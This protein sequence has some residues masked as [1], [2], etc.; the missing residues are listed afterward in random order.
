VSLVRLYKLQQVDIA[1]AR[2]IAHRQA[3]DDGAAQR[4]AVE[5]ATGHL[6]LVQDQIH[7]D[8]AKLKALDLEIRSLDGK[9][10]QV[11]ADMYSGRVRNPKELSAMQDDVAA[12]SR[13]KSG[14]EDEM[15]ALYERAEQLDADK[16][17]A[18]RDLEALSSDA[19]RQARAYQEAVAV[20]DREIE[21][22]ESQRVELVGEIDE[23]I[24]RRYD[25]LRPVKGGVAVVVVRA[26]GICDG[27]H[28]AVPERV[29]S[30]LRRDPAGV[31]TCD[32]CGRILV[33]L[34]PN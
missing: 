14:L 19:E 25:R 30:R 13:T 21:S 3:L 23:D 1:L 28:V 18:T 26:D 24:L 8:Q 9:R 11:E 31:Q 2:A 5:A 22:L 16:T 17:G 12:I 32:G 15:L 10:A 33:V 7:T 4:A 29:V 34:S 20:A 6:A 27:C